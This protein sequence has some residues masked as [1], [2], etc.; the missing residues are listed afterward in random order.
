MVID[1][2]IRPPYKSFLSLSMYRS[3]SPP[4]DSRHVSPFTWECG[5]VP[6]AEKR[7]IELLVSEMDEAGIGQAVV[8]GRQAG[9]KYGFVSNDDV[10]ELGRLYPGRFHLFG[11]V[12]LN[13]VPA[14]VAEV[15]RVVGRMGFKGIAVDGG[16]SDPPVYP[17]DKRFYPIYAKCQELGAILS[18]SMSIFLGPDLSYVEPMRLQHIAADFPDLLIVVPHAGWPYV[19]EFLG[20]AFMYRNVWLAPDFY[21]YIP[22][23]PGASQ[24]VEAANFFMRDRFLFASSYPERPLKQ[25]V[26]EFKRLPFRPEVLEKALYKNA[27]WILGKREK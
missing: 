4:K 20:V 25:T 8:M 5:P 21:V 9:P 24:Y 7:S 15:E 6:S 17:D 19:M 26:E 18:L 16:W 22:G 1:F 23:M 12:S 2:R 10:A 14:A 3:G 11:G 27:E 13:D